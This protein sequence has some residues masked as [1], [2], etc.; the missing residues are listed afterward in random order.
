MEIKQQGKGLFL[1]QLDEAEQENLRE[2]KELFDDCTPDFEEKPS[3]A[4]VLS[5]IIIQGFV[6]M[7]E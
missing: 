2:A 7:A 6:Y 3:E 1:V 5:E 4:E